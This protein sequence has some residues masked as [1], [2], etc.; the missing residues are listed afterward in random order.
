M[1]LL[2][3]VSTAITQAVV[4]SKLNQPLLNILKISKAKTKDK[5]EVTPASKI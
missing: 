1:G 2:L 4:P 5:N 3:N